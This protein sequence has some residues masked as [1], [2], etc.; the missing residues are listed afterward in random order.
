[1]HVLDIVRNPSSAS[2]AHEQLRAQEAAST[3]QRRAH[4]SLVKRVA[5]QLPEESR[6]HTLRLGGIGSTAVT[7]L[8]ARNKDG[9][10][11]DY[12][13]CDL[14]VQDEGLVLVMVC[15]SCIF[16]HHRSVAQSH[17]TLRSWHRR[18]SLDER[19]RGELWINPRPPHEPYTLAG[20]IHTHEPQT[21]PVCS[22][23]FQ[24]DGGKVRAA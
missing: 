18:F 1:M 15:P 13:I 19:R 23:R 3:D 2:A 21:C 11:V 10:V 24:I 22:F 5:A 8:E 9:S 6:L 20:T 4:D 7:V 12:I 14:S 16:R 17:I